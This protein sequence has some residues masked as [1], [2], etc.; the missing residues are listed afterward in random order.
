M[1]KSSKFHIL[2][3]RRIADIEQFRQKYIKKSA[4]TFPVSHSDTYRYPFSGWFC[5]GD[6][7]DRANALLARISVDDGV[8][9]GDLLYRFV[10][11]HA[12]NIGQTAMRLS[13]LAG[14]V[15]MVAAIPAIMIGMIGDV[16]SLTLR[17]GGGDPTLGIP[18]LIPYPMIENGMVLFPFKTLAMISGLITIMV[19]SRLTQSVYQPMPLRKQG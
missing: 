10:R 8:L 19:V 2:R 4:S 14:L 13:I 16:V 17:I 11:R 12:S 15:C 3:L 18:T 5:S 1:W 9:C 7:R 6:D